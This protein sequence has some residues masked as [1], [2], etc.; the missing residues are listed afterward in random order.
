MQQSAPPLL[1]I[2]R[3]RLQGDLLARLLATPDQG[4]TV[5]EL[6]RAA[7]ADVSA[8]SRE[9]SRLV[10]AGLLREER[11]GRTRVVRAD[12]SSPYFTDLANLVTKA[13]GPARTAAQALGQIPGVNSV[14]VFGSWAARA[15]GEPGR[16]P[17]DLDVLIV[18]KPSRVAVHRAAEALE[19]RLGLPV[20]IVFATTQEWGEGS[21]GVLSEIR[22]RP[23][24][25]FT[26]V[27]TG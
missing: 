23:F 21:V 11:L 19:V 20:Q 22:R 18:G 9:L 26:E 10:G 14:V 1:P 8:V 24:Q 4:F 27:S 17:H 7:E 16:A 12:R 6:A 5:G 25:E 15:A 2:F 3:S 13:F